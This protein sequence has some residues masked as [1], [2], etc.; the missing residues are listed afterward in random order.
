MPPLVPPL[1]LPHHPCLNSVSRV[2]IRRVVG[3]HPA[4]RQP[5]RVWTRRERRGQPHLCPSGRRS[6]QVVEKAEDEAAQIVQ[7]AREGEHTIPHH[8]HHCTYTSYIPH[9]HTTT[10][11]LSHTHTRRMRVGRTVRLVCCARMCLFLVAVHMCPSDT[12]SSLTSLSNS[13]THTT[14]HTHITP[15]LTTHTDTLLSPVFLLYPYIYVSV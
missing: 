8:T 5:I 2:R 13:L 14:H 3:A 11:Y 9:T 4:R 1:A 10:K 15:T 12:S 6:R 7:R